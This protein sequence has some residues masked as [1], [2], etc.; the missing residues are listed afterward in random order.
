M[1]SKYDSNVEKRIIQA[2]EEFATAPGLNWTD[3]AEKHKVPYQRLIRRKNG[4]PANNSNGGHNRLTTN[5][6]E[7]ALIAYIDDCERRGFN[8]RHRDIE[9]AARELLK[10]EDGNQVK[11][12]YSN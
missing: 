6:Q 7:A 12:L 1:S 5:E 3:L 4:T 11:D 2:I 9:K 8:C 10:N